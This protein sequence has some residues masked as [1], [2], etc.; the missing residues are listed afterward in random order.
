MH[1]TDSR[2]RKSKKDWRTENQN[3]QK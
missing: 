1:L 3:G 2:E